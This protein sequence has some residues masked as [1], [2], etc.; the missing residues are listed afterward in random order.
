MALDPVTLAFAATM[1]ASPPQPA[2]PPPKKAAAVKTATVQKDPAFGKFAL[3]VLKCYHGTARYLNA[4]IEQR[5]WV[6]ATKYD[7][8]GSA[9]ITIDYLGISGATYAMTVG[10]LAKPGAIKTVIATD[11]AKIPAYD[12]CELANWY[13]VN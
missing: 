9:L 3:A 13:V 6:D 2:T 10:V 8:K 12:Q 11:N 4:T 7:G 5:P 1:L